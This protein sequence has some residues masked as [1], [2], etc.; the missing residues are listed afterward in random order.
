VFAD[1][2]PVTFANVATDDRVLAPLLEHL[3]AGEGAPSGHD[4][5]NGMAP[6]KVVVAALEQVAVALPRELG[7]DTS[8]WTWGSVHTN[9]FDH[10]LGGR[11]NL[12]PIAVGG[13]LSTISAARYSPVVNGAPVIRPDINEAPNVRMVVEL[14]PGA[15]QMR[16]VLPTG[17]SGVID[18]PHYADQLASWQ[19]DQLHPCHFDRDDVMAHAAITTTLPAGTR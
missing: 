19:H 17:E 7:A 5:L 8:K 11:Y 14:V 12:G 9:T 3:L 15:V 13:G 1:D 2:L 10:P 16:G 6:A 4:Y 18:S